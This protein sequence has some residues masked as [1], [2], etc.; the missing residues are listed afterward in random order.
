M[1]NTYNENLERVRLAAAKFPV[2]FGLRAFP[3]ERFSIS[4]SGSY[5]NDY[6]EV[7]LYTSIWSAKLNR[8][9]SFAKGSPAELQAELVMLPD[10]IGLPPGLVNCGHCG[11]QYDS[12]MGSCGCFDNG[13]E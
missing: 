10:A 6:N 9:S 3:G 8:W 12:T 11:S 7:Q 5:V 4:L 2:E 13:C 1:A